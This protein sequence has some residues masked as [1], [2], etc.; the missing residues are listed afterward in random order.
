M[1]TIKPQGIVNWDEPLVHH[2]TNCFIAFLLSL[3]KEREKKQSIRFSSSSS[4]SWLTL[5]QY[6]HTQ[7]SQMGNIFSLLFRL[8]SIWLFISES[9]SSIFINVWGIDKDQMKKKK[10]SRRITDDLQFLS[11]SASASAIPSHSFSGLVTQTNRNSNINNRHTSFLHRD[12]FIN[13]YWIRKR[14]KRKWWRRVVSV[15]IL[16]IA[17][18]QSQN[19][20]ISLL[21]VWEDEK[22]VQSRLTAS[23]FLFFLLLSSF[24]SVLV[25]CSCAFPSKKN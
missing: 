9:K 5:T 7:F 15:D 4:S 13:H 25:F 1:E 22:C 10:K 19:E 23:I 18:D 11:L 12:F 14:T 2:H 20:S 24:F 3:S 6:T 8:R 17:L 21:S 16:Q